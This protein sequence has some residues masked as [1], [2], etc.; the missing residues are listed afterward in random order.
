[1][2]NSE[3]YEYSILKYIESAAKGSFILF[4]GEFTYNLTLALGS[5]VIARVLTSEGY[6][7]FSLA[8][9]PPSIVASLLS[10]GIDTAASRYSQMFLMRN[11]EKGVR[12]VIKASLLVKTVTGLMGFALCFIFA[13][14]LA[15]FFINRPDLAPYVRVTAVVVLLQNIYNLLLSIFIGLERVT[16]TTFA[17]IAY[18]VVKTVAS[19]YMLLLLQLSVL[20]ALLGNIIGYTL[21]L[22]AAFLF[23]MQALRG[24][25]KNNDSVVGITAIAKDMLRYG[26]PLYVASLIP[27]IVSGAYQNALL[28]YNL[29][30]KDIG[31]YR[32]MANLGVLVSVV[33]APIS[34]ALLPLFTKFHSN[35]N[36]LSKVAR[37][38]NKYIAFVTTPVT[39]AAMIF[40][41]EIMYLF[42]G[43]DYLFTC[44]LLPLLLAPNLLASLGGLTIPTILNAI[45]DTK[46]NM[47]STIIS[48]AVFIP[49]S[50]VLTISAKLW[51]FLIASLLSSIVGLIFLSIYV[52]KYIAKPVDYIHV[53]KTYFA[54]ALSA[55]LT[56]LVFLIPVPRFVSVVRIV[57]GFI[58]FLATY[59]PTALVL[60]VVSEDDVNFIVKAFEKFPI[61]NIVIALLGGYAKA[62][63]KL[64]SRGG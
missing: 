18:S 54:S 45:G 13:E 21:A 29:P 56:L 42:Y 59:I 8:L 58:I 33:T 61:V 30:D 63:A 40:S 25:G 23:L 46:A 35:S 39:V 34:A 3:S 55:I 1:M 50:Y 60:G 7:A 28:A 9:V 5:I 62:V 38:T 31:G 12:A 51:G 6:G 36:E 48:T 53:C 44:S 2:P 26:L 49:A 16:G 15:R 22:V 14:P 41:R 37:T 4:L 20:G 27:I 10:L 57:L 17:K 47:Y 32:A 11:S 43:A 52:E 19:I 24:S 64:I